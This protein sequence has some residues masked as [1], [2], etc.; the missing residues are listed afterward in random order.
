MTMCAPC[1]LNL[2]NYFFSPIVT[3]LN[4]LDIFWAWGQKSFYIHKGLWITENCIKLSNLITVSTKHNRYLQ[5]YGERW[6]EEGKEQARERERERNE[7]CRQCPFIMLMQ[8]MY[9]RR[10]LRNLCMRVCLRGCV[11]VCVSNEGFARAHESFWERLVWFRCY[12]SPMTVSLA[13]THKCA[14]KTHTDK[15]RSAVYTHT[16]TPTHNLTQCH[17]DTHTYTQIKLHPPTHIHTHTL[18]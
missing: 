17:S 6:V 4:L 14:Q 7:K 11:W 9:Q 13:N 15:H 2:S 12:S 5:P 3:H 8:C 18:T 1:C 10:R 16:H